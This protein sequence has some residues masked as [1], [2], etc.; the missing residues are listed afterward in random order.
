MGYLDVCANDSYV[1]ALYSPEEFAACNYHS[2]YILVYDWNGN[3][4]TIL[5]LRQNVL[6]IAVNS[7]TLFLLTIDDEGEYAIKQVSLRQALYK[8]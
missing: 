3:K 8:S 2:P 4:I 1:F 6:D 5:D 7:S